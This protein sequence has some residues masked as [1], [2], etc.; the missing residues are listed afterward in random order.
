MAACSQ[1]AR[2]AG[3]AVHL[4]VDAAHPGA[5]VP[6][7]FLGLAFEYDDILRYA[8]GGAPDPAVVRLLRNVLPPGSGPPVLRLGGNSTDESWWNPDGRPAPPGI[9]YA[10]DRAWLQAVGGTASALGARL[11]L[12]V[13]LGLD[14]PGAGASWA[15]AASAGLGS[16]LAAFEIGN[17]PDLYPGHAYG[18]GRTVRPPGYGFGQYEAEYR[19]YAAALR[20]A[21]GP[22]VPLAGPAALTP[23]WMAGLPGFLQRE[24]PA[25]VTY[26]QYPL[27]ACGVKPG[28]AGYP[29][30]GE[31]LSDRS[32]H[33]LATEVVPFVREAAAAGRGLRVDEV[34]SAICHGARGVS[35]T[36]ASAL[37]V[38][39][40]LFEYAAIGVAGV[41]VQTVSW[42]AYTPFVPGP[43]PVVEPEYY[44][45]WLAAQALPAG[46]RLVPVRGAGGD[47]EA[48]ATLD[49][50]GTLRL[51]LLH[52]GSGG[53]A[54]VDVQL[55]GRGPARVARL[56]APSLD[57]RTGV[58]LGG[59]TFDGSGDGRP[60][61]TAGGERVDQ[62]GGTYRLRLPAASGAL[63]TLGA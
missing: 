62:A 24:S 32:T 33:R 29:T 1:A 41:N 47:V 10:V 21:L 5:T 39:D 56:Q 18:A 53:P 57:A 48:W 44:G 49:G 19:A 42:A 6:A 9:S 23:A 26:H 8:G 61:G 12:G 15:V 45:L 34:N 14:D 52:R 25:S 28:Q 37:W 43:R 13:N 31:L 22:G 54:G 17:E 51:V 46:A 50:R 36:F 30:I 38:A 35:D 11:I 16:G 55:P 58:S 2:P 4:T 60:R 40:L 20:Q 27:S 59:A 63:V 3:Q 7:S